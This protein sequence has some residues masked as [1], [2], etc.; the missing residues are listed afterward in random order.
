MPSASR[1]SLVFYVSPLL[2]YVLIGTLL[3]SLAMVISGGYF[4]TSFYHTYLLLRAE[5]TRLTE[6][7]EKELAAL[8]LTIKR[9]QKDTGITRHILG[10]EKN[11][12][13]G[14][15]LGQG[16]MPST[17]ISQNFPTDMMENNSTLP[18]MR[19]KSLSLLDQADSLKENLQELVMIIGERR[20]ILDS[21]PSILPV[22]AKGYRMTSGFGWRRSPFTG[23]KE[24]H[25]GLDIAAPKGTPIIA[26]ANG[27]VIKTVRHRYR[28]KYLQVDHG[29][30]C[31]T[32]Y[33]HLSGFNVRAG[34]I[35]R[36]GQVIG[37]M[38]STGR[39]TGSHL[40]YEIEINGRVLN[41]I[42]YIL[43]VSAIGSRRFR[44]EETIVNSKT[45]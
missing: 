36:R 44:S 22:E 6:Q 19:V 42:H 32:T 1:G 26:P 9:I 29:R 7:Q 43:N 4:A 33:A 28:G 20:Q 39:S 30:N 12:Q 5:N 40:H 45:E 16:G 14:I 34:Q 35:V 8:Q 31:I 24:F 10:V 17:H 13:R 18:L 21:T 2:I 3:L 37:Y 25:D 23:L 27:R 38:G 15:G 41:P 11:R